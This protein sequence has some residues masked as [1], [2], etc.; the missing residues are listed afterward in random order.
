M[1][2]KKLLLVAISVGMFLVITIAAAILFFAPN[3]VP[4]SARAPVS[5]P[6]VAD[7]PVPPAPPSIAAIQQPPVVPP[8]EPVPPVHVDAVELVRRAG[9][10]PGLQQAPEGIIPQ[11]TDFRV[12]GGAVINVP[13]PTAPA[14]PDT[15]PAGRAVPAATARPAPP[16]QRPPAP[17][18]AAPAP[19]PAARPPSPPPVAAARPPQ[20]AQPRPQVPTRV[21]N[22][23]WVQTGAFSTLARAEGVRDSLASRGIVSI[24]ENRNV[25]GRN[26]FRVRVGPYTSHNEANFWLSLIRSIDGFEDSQVRQ[27]VRQ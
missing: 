26:L 5:H 1:E 3:N 13:R 16:A 2:K 9:E 21:Q 7:T 22:D 14:V 25:N 23:Y 17:P 6:A 18:A 27:T 15:P 11:G 19:A 4:V 8:P 10:V 12:N 20:A 24:I